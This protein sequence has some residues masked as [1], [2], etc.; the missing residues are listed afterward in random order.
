M[1]DKSRLC[2]MTQ[3]EVDSYLKEKNI[4]VAVM[5]EHGYNKDGDWAEEI[6]DD[7]GYFVKFGD[8]CVKTV[9]LWGFSSPNGFHTFSWE[10]P[11]LTE[12]KAQYMT[13]LFHKLYEE[14]DV[15][16][17]SAEA[18]SLSYVIS[19]FQV[20]YVER[21][22]DKTPDMSTEEGQEEVRKKLLGCIESGNVVI[23]KAVDETV[24]VRG[25][26]RKAS[27]FDKEHLF[28][29]SGVVED[30]KTDGVQ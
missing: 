30:W 1:S 2:G 8:D 11:K 27:E 14:Y 6:R 7:K 13:V 18:L 15:S 3:E 20:P 29:K 21:G 12:A 9:Q 19:E 25:E 17:A 10:E 5:M 24:I 26:E 16:W 28:T 22:W 4:K 23:P